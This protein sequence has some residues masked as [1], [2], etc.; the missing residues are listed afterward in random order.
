LHRNPVT[1]VRYP[2]RNPTR[3]CD[4]RQTPVQLSYIY[5][6]SAPN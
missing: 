2:C 1:P 3:A 5:G 4:S 6:I